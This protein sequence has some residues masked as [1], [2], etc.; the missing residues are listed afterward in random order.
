ME[1]RAD[2]RPLSLPR[3]A[4]RSRGVLR[5]PLV[6]V[7]LGEPLHELLGVRRID[8]REEVSRAP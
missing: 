4:E 1:R 5:T 8:A 6:L 3:D 7:D 2:V